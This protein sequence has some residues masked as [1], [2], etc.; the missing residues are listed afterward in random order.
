MGVARPSWCFL[1]VVL[2]TT[3]KA[4]IWT[5]GQWEDKSTHN[6]TAKVIM[7]FLRWYPVVCCCWLHPYISHSVDALDGCVHTPW[8][9][10]FFTNLWWVRR[11][12][13]EEKNWHHYISCG[14]HAL[15]PLFEVYIYIYIYIYVQ[16]CKSSGSHSQLVS[17]S[18]DIMSS[19]LLPLW[20]SLVLLCLH[21]PCFLVS[22]LKW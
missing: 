19:Y 9:C 15:Y 11:Y 2:P 8:Q 10:W 13:F 14:S 1:R 17:G 16:L 18:V 5:G 3:V 7:C 4:S 22:I 12:L 20:A 6:S 21:C